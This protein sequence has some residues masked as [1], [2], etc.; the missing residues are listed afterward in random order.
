MRVIFLLKETPRNR[1]EIPLFLSGM[2]MKLSSIREDEHKEVTSCSIGPTPRL[3]VLSMRTEVKIFLLRA[4]N[5]G[6][7]MSLP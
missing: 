3:R 1:V 7:K 2:T 4:I 5:V 6:R